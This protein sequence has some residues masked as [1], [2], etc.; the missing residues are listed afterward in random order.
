M[1]QSD[2]ASG[3]P[4]W[5]AGLDAVLAAFT[6]EQALPPAYADMARQW[7]L[8]LADALWA[9][10]QR[11]AVEC[12]ASPA[13]VVGLQG[14][15][16][17]GKSTLAALLVHLFNATQPSSAVALSLDDF[18]L[19]RAERL[20]LAEQ[21]HPLLQTRGVPGTHDTTLALNLLDRLQKLG[22]PEQP[23]KMQI[24]R[25]DKARDDR[26]PAAQWPELAGPMRL[27]VL[28]GWCVG[29]P[30]EPASALAHPVNALERVE[31]PDGVWRGYV[32]QALASAYQTLFAR[33]DVLLVLQ[34]PGFDVVQ[35]WRRQQEQK[36]RASRPEAGLRTLDDEA[37]IRFIAHYERLTR[38][39]LA[40]MPERADQCFLLDAAQRV[41]AA[42]PMR[43]GGSTD[44]N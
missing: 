30:P 26:M 32:N 1:K 20:V 16:G 34:A 3:A 13:L 27:I 24:P 5:G 35:R 36:L 42:E 6:A 29:L 38:H 19:T 40:V 28:E 10:S 4:F 11:Q 44:G 22:I 17:S 39:G 15:Q 41:V 14:V 25:F 9:R 2:P 31:D 43:L 33:L 8:P 37:L 21:V 23:G 12:P 18:Y 7:F